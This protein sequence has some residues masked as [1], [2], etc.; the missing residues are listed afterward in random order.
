MVFAWFIRFAVEKHDQHPTK[1]LYWSV[2]LVMQAWLANLVTA[3]KLLV[4]SLIRP[5]K[6]QSKPAKTILQVEFAFSGKPLTSIPADMPACLADTASFVA[7]LQVQIA[8]KLDEIAPA[9]STTLSCDVRLFCGHNGPELTWPELALLP[10]QPDE[11]Y[12]PPT[13]S[14]MAMKRLAVG[15]VLVAVRSDVGSQALKAFTAERAKHGERCT[16]C[17]FACTN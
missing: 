12:L 16:F 13:E 17:L 5:D 11:P 9:G 14:R 3:Q 4:E 15:S 6:S 1:M 8:K 7:N 10:H 2:M